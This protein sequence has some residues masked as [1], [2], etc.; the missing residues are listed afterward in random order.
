MKKLL[1]ILLLCLNGLNSK[2]QF[3]TIPDAEFSN[4]LNAYYPN[5]MVGNQ[6]DTTCSDIVNETTMD[7]SFLNIFD[8]TGIQYFDNL[9]IL[10]CSSDS[11]LLIPKLPSKLTSL[12]CSDNQLINLPDLPRSLLE[13]N[14]NMNQLTSFPLLPDSLSALLCADNSLS[15]IPSLPSTLEVLSCPSN[16]I[17]NLPSIPSSVVYLDCALNPLSSIAS[18][19]NSLLSFYCDY[20]P[21]SYIPFL[22]DSMSVFSIEGCTDLLCMPIIKTINNFY[23]NNSGISCFPNAI[24][25]VN[26]FPSVANVPICDML[27]A[28]NCDAG[29]KVRGTVY[30][31]NNY[32]CFL[33]SLEYLNSNIKLQIFKNSALI[34]QV[35]S[36]NFGQYT[37]AVDTG[38]YVYSVDTIGQPYFVD[39]PSTNSYT[40]N[41]ISPTSFFDNKDF[42]IHCKSGYDIGVQ[43]VCRIGGLFRPGFNADIL[44]NVNDLSKKYNL[45]CAS[46]VSGSVKVVL[47]GPCVY[48]GINSGALTPIVIGDTLKYSVSDFGI[49]NNGDF[50]FKILTNVS[51]QIGQNICMDI[52]VDP[53]TGDNN[54]SNNFYSHCFSV[55]NSYDPN[56]K[57]V[58]PPG[59]IDTAQYWL[60]YTVRF[61]NTGTAPALQVRVEDTLD[62][63]IDEGSFELLSYSHQPITQ[64]VGKKVRFTFPN[65]NLPDST[66]NEPAS[67]GFVQYKVKRKNGLSLGTQIHNTAYIYFDFNSPVVTNTTTNEI[68][69]GTVGISE[70]TN[71]G[72]VLYPNPIAAGQS[73]QLNFN[74]DFAGKGVLQLLDISGRKVFSSDFNGNVQILSLPDIA[75]GIYLCELWIGSQ[76]LVKKVV[77]K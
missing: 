74:D 11:L 21:I 6:M 70:N 48:D 32:N 17:V 71:I 52:I 68:G 4:A 5:C 40:S 24:S 66:T 72:F 37:F 75:P 10:N 2:A 39:C 12:D 23:W 36:N 38:V 56:V 54:T 57:E 59:Q 18:L 62:A 43:S 28:N 15:S 73:L 45:N 1:L 29:W 51:A 49:I 63:N 8:L 58:S 3:V 27:N 30:S 25:S 31:D 41:L 60:N 13:L 34:G 55:V 65:I 46:G 7:I 14:C 26:A 9:V 77:V 76:H 44:V 64:I 33:D 61:Q 53:I 42:S 19:P 50:S 67:H 35:Y 22:P 16:L 47:H 69:I 20:T